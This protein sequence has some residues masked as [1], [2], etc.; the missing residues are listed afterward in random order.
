MFVHDGWQLLYE[1]H[2][3]GIPNSLSLK[4]RSTCVSHLHPLLEAQAAAGAASG[5]L[6]ASKAASKHVL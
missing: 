2:Q 3:A 4:P 5:A 1:L 6:A